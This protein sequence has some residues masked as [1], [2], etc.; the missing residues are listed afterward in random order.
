[1]T[2]WQEFKLTESKIVYAIED[3]NPSEVKPYLDYYMEKGEINSMEELFTPPLGES[4]EYARCEF[5]AEELKIRK[6]SWKYQDQEYQLLD[7]NNFWG[8]NENGV[9]AIRNFDESEYTTIATN[10]DQCLSMTIEHIFE[11][12]LAYFQCLRSDPEYYNESGRYSHQLIEFA[13]SDEGR[14]ASQIE[15]DAYQTSS[16]KRKII[17]AEEARLENLYLSEFIIEQG[18]D[19]DL[20]ILIEHLNSGNYRGEFKN[21]KSQLY[22]IIWLNN[23]MQFLYISSSYS[24]YLFLINPDGQLTEIFENWY[25][26]GKKKTPLMSALCKRIYTLEHLISSLCKRIRASKR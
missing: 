7:V 21:P 6:W 10:G 23:S 19:S 26:S 20:N 11:S 16:S 1:M 24:N 3:V 18:S 12:R 14:I 5:S 9:I 22:R 25:F 4:I 8:D 15:E 13:N 17:A 2:Y